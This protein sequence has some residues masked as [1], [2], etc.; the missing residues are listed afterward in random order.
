MATTYVEGDEMVSVWRPVT[1]E[2]PPYGKTVRL[3]DAFYNGLVR[4]EYTEEDGF[5]S[6]EADRPLLVTHWTF[7]DSA[8]APSPSDVNRVR[9]EIAG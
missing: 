1:E 2:M 4:G 8:Q 9:K 3:Y 5:V 6:D 7:S